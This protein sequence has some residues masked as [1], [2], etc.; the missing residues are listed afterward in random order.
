MSE[1]VFDYGF[2][3][4][5]KEKMSDDDRYDL[6]ERLWDE[7]T[8]YHINNEGT[9]LYSAIRGCEYGIRFTKTSE[10]NPSTFI[11]SIP[12]YVPEIDETMIRGYSCYW[13]NGTDSDMSCMTLE[14]YKENLND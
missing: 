5:L 10:T 8:G 4:P 7:N 13:Y 2:M 6:S 12:D 9:I 14:R 1:N 3:V 11:S